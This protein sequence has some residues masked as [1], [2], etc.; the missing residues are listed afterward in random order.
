MQITAVTLNLVDQVFGVTSKVR[1]YRARF[2]GRRESKCSKSVR[3]VGTS[4]T[5]IATMERTRRKLRIGRI[6]REFSCN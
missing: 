5:V 3:N 6:R 1:F 2:P 4:R